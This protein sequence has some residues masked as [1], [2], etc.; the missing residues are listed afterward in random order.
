MPNRRF[1]RLAGLMSF[2]FGVLVCLPLV[3]PAEA[4][5]GK[6]KVRIVLPIV[7]EGQ[8]ECALAT[9]DG[10][11]AWQENAAL[12]V[13][14]SFVSEWI[15]LPR[16]EIGFCIREGEKLVA[17]ASFAM[18]EDVE[19]AL[20]VLSPGQ[21][22]GRFTAHVVDTRK[23]KFG[24]GEFLLVNT[25]ET[26]CR[27]TIGQGETGSK[28][29]ET[30]VTRPEADENRMN[31]LKVSY[32]DKDGNEVVC[33]DRFAAM[34]EGAR[35]YLFIVPDPNLVVRVETMSEFGPFD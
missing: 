35:N 28:P 1:P 32:E 30:H 3:H 7:P 12:D 9:K 18:P 5:A 2:A 33:H 8:A 14:P 23:T 21:E 17:V 29:G 15:E 6:V 10:E 19:R 24:Q 13:R 20:V 11:G 34:A 22:K 4:A 16:E 26:I 25:S 27:V 31:R